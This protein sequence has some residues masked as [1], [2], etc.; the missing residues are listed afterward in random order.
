MEEQERKGYKYQLGGS[1]P[2]QFFILFVRT[3]SLHNGLNQFQKRP[4][5]KNY[6]M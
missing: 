3:G 2:F 5:A 1:N 4:P 6:G